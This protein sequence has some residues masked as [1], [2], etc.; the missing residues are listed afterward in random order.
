MTLKNYVLYYHYQMMIT[1][2][3]E[4]KIK[5]QIQIQI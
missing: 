2:F 4:R 1:F 3:N 5:W